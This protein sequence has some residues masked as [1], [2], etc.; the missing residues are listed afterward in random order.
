[1]L[2]LERARK[3]MEE[4]LI[5]KTIREGSGTQFDPDIVITFLKAHNEGLIQSYM[6]TGSRPH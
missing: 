4:D 2:N 1:M 3:K 5:V 6:K